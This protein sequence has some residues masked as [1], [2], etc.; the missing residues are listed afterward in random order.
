MAPHMKAPPQASACSGTCDS[1]NILT[2]HMMLRTGDRQQRLRQHSTSRGDS[3]SYMGP[4]DSL[5]A[6]PIHRAAP[7]SR[8]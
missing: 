1:K 2:L 7:G 8:T 3:R 4:E 5:Q 6:P